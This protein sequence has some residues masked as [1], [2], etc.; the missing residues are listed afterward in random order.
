MT[1]TAGAILLEVFPSVYTAP[2]VRVI[3]CAVQG[4]MQLG[5]LLGRE[6]VAT[7]DEHFHLCAVRQVRWLVDD[8]AAVLHLGLQRLHAGHSIALRAFSHGGGKGVAPGLRLAS[9]G[10]L[11]RSPAV[12]QM[13]ESPDRAAPE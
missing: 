11:R 13:P 2:G 12:S 3:E 10:L 1:L 6:I 8:H 4:G 7:D 9:C 5:A